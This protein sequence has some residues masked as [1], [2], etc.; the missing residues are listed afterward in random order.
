MFARAYLNGDGSACGKYMSVSLTV[1]PG[2][3]DCLLKWPMNMKATFCL[4][5]QS[6]SKE[7]VIKRITASLQPL[8]ELTVEIKN[9][10]ALNTVHQDPSPYVLDDT[11]FFIVEVRTIEPEIPS[12]IQDAINMIRLGDFEENRLEFVSLETTETNSFETEPP[13]GILP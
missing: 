4:I 12:H 10:T 1:M 9:F 2:E 5:D 6:T 7:H 3:Y 13:F 11:M 8:S